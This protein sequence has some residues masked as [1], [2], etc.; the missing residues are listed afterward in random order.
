MIAK[1]KILILGAVAILLVACGLRVY[2]LQYKDIAHMDEILSIVL[3]EYNE[4]GWGKDFET[5]TI[6]TAEQMQEMSLWNDSTLKGALNDVKRLWVNNRDDPHT[7][8]YYS[9]LR[10][11]HIGFIH[12]DLKQTFYRGVGLNFVF[13]LCG[14]ACAFVLARR[15]FGESYFILVFLCLAFWNPA[16]IN[17]TLF[18][19]PYALQE[20][21]FLLFC[22]VLLRI[23]QSFKKPL[24]NTS[25]FQCENY[26]HKVKKPIAIWSACSIVDLGYCV[27]LECFTHKVRY[28]QIVAHK[29]DT[30]AKH[31]GYEIKGKMLFPSHIF[32][33]HSPYIVINP[34]LDSIHLE[35]VLDGAFTPIAIHIDENPR[36]LIF[37]TKHNIQA[38]EILGNIPYTLHITFK[39]YA[40]LVLAYVIGCA[41]IVCA[42]LLSYEVLILSS[43]TALL[44]LSGYFVAIFV[45]MIYALATLW[46]YRARAYKDKLF[47]ITALVYA[48]FLS[49]LLYPRYF[50][51]LTGGRG[52]E[53][54]DKLNMDYVVQHFGANTQHF[55]DI[56]STQLSYGV[57]CISLCG[58]CLVLAQ[59]IKYRAT[60]L[61]YMKDF[62][63]VLPPMPLALILGLCAFV[64][65]F[66]VI[67][68]APYKDLRYIMSI[69]A[70]LL[71]LPVYSLASMYN[72]VSCY[73]RKYT[74]PMLGGGG[75]MSDGNGK[76]PLC[77]LFFCFVGMLYLSW[78]K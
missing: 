28:A 2:Y 14:F 69:F 68:I 72:L 47:F 44:L 42:G 33:D 75:G 67:F 51:A 25:L 57:I 58:I 12:T 76:A 22:Y 45:V 10:L 19:R 21:S 46:A 43:V 29:V 35:S 16:S 53:V 60:L 52:K 38:G 17:N 78:C 1:S 15:L 50:L 7:N 73:L 11:W 59:V 41:V 18:I 8:L 26:K 9:L 36:Y 55:F 64:W 24:F 37:D 66:V 40:M 34:M 3:A 48:M 56:L 62:N 23:L 30:N 5:Y 61:A 74:L 63:K 6:Y 49:T 71:L 70:I 31:L 77:A 32:R 4:Y 27:S 13:L 39:L 65:A 54:G 20:M